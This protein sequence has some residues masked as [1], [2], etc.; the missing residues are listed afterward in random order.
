MR[1]G[2]C[3]CPVPRAGEND[4]ELPRRERKGSISAASAPAAAD[5][6]WTLTSC[7]SGEGSLADTD[8]LE[9]VVRKDY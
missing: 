2:L 9:I 3:E 7:R 4:Y 8:F 5:S 1:Q 6:I